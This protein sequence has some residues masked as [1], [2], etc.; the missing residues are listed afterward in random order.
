MSKDL[1]ARDFL[2]SIVVFLVALPLCMGVAIASG[3]PPAMGLISGMVGGLVVGSMAR[4]SLLV[5]GPTAG[6]A[7][8]VWQLVEK[9][10][11]EMLGPVVMAAGLMQ[12]LAGSLKWGQYFR[13]VAPPVVYATL[14]G[15]GILIAASQFHVMVDDTPKGSGIQNLLSIPQAI[16]KGMT[17]GEGAIH[18][19]A[20]VLGLVTIGSI[21]LW[22]KFRPVRLAFVPA[23]LVGVVAAALVAFTFKYPVRY[24]DVPSSLLQVA[25]WPSVGALVRLFDPAILGTALSVALIATTETLLSAI[26]VDR[27][28]TGP[29]TEFD[30]QLK[31]QGIG[32]LVCGAIGALPL[33]GVAVRSSANVQAGARTSLSTILHGV[34]LLAIV[35]A[36]PALLRM[37]S[38]ASLA[39]LLVYTGYKLVNLDNIRELARYGR[40]PIATYFATVIGIVMTNLL[41]GVLI[42]VALSIAHL[43]YTLTHAEISLQMDP[44]RNRAEL[45]LEGSV[46]FLALPRLAALLD[47]I[48]PGAEMHVH[49]QNLQ[50]IDHACMDAL[51]G[52]QRQYE[53]LGSKMFVEWDHLMAK[54][55]GLRGKSGDR[56]PS[57]V[58]RTSPL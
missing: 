46:T 23:T 17:F 7:V 56:E 5:S 51:Y 12:L 29:R 32:N 39:A 25:V 8:L 57:L 30:R 54:H 16:S 47:T 45:A 18:H 14:A 50:H 48:P 20:A 43:I 58:E 6:L 55:R 41:M 52:W 40:F 38:A 24:L 1:F 4:S 36:L 34:W 9:H 11:I 49:I 19:W 10:G 21:V 28:H 42:G 27:L 15:L 33:A 3:V 31:A 26:A 44:E 37:V 13:A 2:A 22:A 53:T 35:V